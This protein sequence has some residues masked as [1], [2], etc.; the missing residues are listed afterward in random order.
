M[1]AERVFRLV[2]AALML[3][4]L[5]AC[6]IPSAGYPPQYELNFIRACEAQNPPTGVCQCTWDKIEA[7]IP[8]SEFDAFERMSASQRPSSPTQQRLTTF[9]LECVGK[10]TGP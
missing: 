6:G 4:T 5:S 7:Q 9:A 2:A 10:P 1:S 3:A 8:R